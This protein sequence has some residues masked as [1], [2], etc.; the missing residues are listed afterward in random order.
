VVLLER[1]MEALAEDGARLRRR[2]DFER[3][4]RKWGRPG[5]M[6]GVEKFRL[7]AWMVFR[8]MGIRV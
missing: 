2:L 6:N 7:A 4:V 1:T 8:K 3:C 5:R